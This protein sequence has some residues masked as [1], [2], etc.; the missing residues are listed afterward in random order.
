MSRRSGRAPRG[1]SATYQD[2]TIGVGGA[3]VIDSTTPETPATSCV[4]ATCDAE[5]RTATVD[6]SDSPDDRNGDDGGSDPVDGHEDQAYGSLR[7]A[8][9]RI[10]G[11]VGTIGVRLPNGAPVRAASAT[12][13]IAWL[14]TAASAWLSSNDWWLAPATTRWTLLRGCATRSICVVRQPVG[15]D[16]CGEHAQRQVAEVGHGSA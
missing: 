8:S 3:D 12:W 4:A 7:G 15:V 5:E 9:S 6:E 14:A 1:V 13:A 16:R 10:E 2:M 11:V